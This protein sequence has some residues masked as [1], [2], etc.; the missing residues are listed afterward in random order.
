MTIASESI[1]SSMEKIP[2]APK[3]WK[4]WLK[5]PIFGA[6]GAKSFWKL[7]WF[8]KNSSI[9]VKIEHFIARKCILMHKMSKKVEKIALYKLF[10]EISKVTNFLKI[11]I[12][13]WP[14]PHWPP[15]LNSSPGENPVLGVHSGARDPWPKGEGTS[16]GGDSLQVSTSLAMIIKPDQLAIVTWRRI[17]NFSL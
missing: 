5:W 15:P 4:N 14:K 16:P 6:A 17:E 3:N 9:F 12:L 8:S 7:G 11:P 2:K 13:R 10:F 1:C